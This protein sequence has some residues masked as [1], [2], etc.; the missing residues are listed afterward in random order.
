[1]LSIV[2]QEQALYSVTYLAGFIN[3]EITIDEILVALP[4]P[5]QKHETLHLGRGIEAKP[6]KE[7][8]H[9]FSLCVQ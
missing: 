6:F 5:F 9:F 3:P 2:A 7:K 8:Y 4:W 1:M